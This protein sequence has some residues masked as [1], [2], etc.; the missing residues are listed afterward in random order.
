MSNIYVQKVYSDSN[1]KNINK[2]SFFKEIAPK[3]HLSYSEKMVFLKALLEIFRL[4]A[5]IL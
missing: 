3:F 4:T 2:I 1:F 5:S